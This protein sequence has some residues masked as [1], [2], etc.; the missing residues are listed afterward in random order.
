MREFVVELGD[1]AT[2]DAFAAAFN[3]GFCR[4]VGGEWGGQNWNAFHDYLS[5]PE[6]QRF[7]LVFRDW[8]GCRGLDDAARRMVQAIV[9]DNPHVLAVYGELDPETGLPEAADHRT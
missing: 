4:R 8:G 5:W 3:D 7:R 2:W 6:E 9:A 1:A